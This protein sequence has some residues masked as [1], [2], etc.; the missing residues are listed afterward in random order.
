MQ[1]LKISGGSVAKGGVLHAQDLGS[2]F[3]SACKI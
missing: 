2:N 3:T 1:S